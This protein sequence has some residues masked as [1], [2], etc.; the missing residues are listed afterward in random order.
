MLPLQDR[1]ESKEAPDPLEA[2]DF[3][4]DK[5]REA[6]LVPRASPVRKP[7]SYIPDLCPDF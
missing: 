3:P 1:R 2:Q 4:V 6:L 5:G 7:L